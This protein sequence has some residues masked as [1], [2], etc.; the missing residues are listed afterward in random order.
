MK[1]VRALSV[2]ALFACA[3]AQA[4]ESPG[5]HY[6]PY[7]SSGI[8]ALGE[9]AG[10]HVTLPWGSPAANYVIR[11]NNLT[12]IGRGRIVPGKPATIE[13]KLD[14]P[15]MV[16]VEVTENSPGA[17]P[18]ALGAAVAPEQI[19]PAIPAPAD[20]DAFW[21]AK[22][23]ALRKVPAKP[24]LT[25]KPSD[26]DGVDFAILRMDHLDGKHVWGQVAKPRDPSGKKKYPGLVL[27]Q[28]ASPPYP[29]QKPW[30]TDRAAE[31][32]LAVN[33]EP[34]DVMPDQPR[35]YYDALPEALKKYN[36][37][38][39][40]NRDRNYFLYMYL[41]DIRAVDYL[42]SRK[43]WD[44][45]TLVVM[46]TSMGGQQSLCTAAFHPKVTA[47]LVN[48]PAGADANGTA[49]GRKTG[50]PNWDFNDTKVLETAQYFDT[51]NCAGRIKVP[52]LVS[53]GFIDTVTPPVGIWAAYNQI[54]GPKQAAPMPESPHNHLAT[55]EQSMPWTRAS[56]NW[57]SA[58]VAGRQPIE[59]ADFAMPRTDANS[60]K[61]HDELLAKRKAGQIDLYFM[62]DSITRRWGT[63]DEQYQDLLANWN[64]NFKGW[65]AANF[66][67]GADRTQNM[68]WRLQNGELDGVNPKVV[69][70]LAGTNNVGNATPLGDAEARAADVARGVTALVRE[71]RSRAPAATL[72]ITG[73]TPRDDNLSVMPVIDSANR[74]IARLADGKSIRYININEQIAFPDGRLRDG[75]AFDGLHLTPKAY[76]HWADA[77]K[78]ILTEIL[79]PPAAVD[80]A[81]P[82]SGDPSA[83]RRQSNS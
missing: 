60:M 7:K 70:L 65:N 36:T 81:P 68:L 22:L 55:P 17:K 61:A 52:S 53:M 47:M 44:G 35:E 51:V 32:W 41:A 71:I 2:A 45:K 30:V 4:D 6:V 11:Q 59:R 76:Q 27:L 9:T 1:S 57:L 49:H 56:A 79:G 64:A 78:P 39:T 18:K 50:Y 77:L 72:V 10:W 82:P 37:I 42:A 73:I 69:V 66:G 31:G 48:V 38:E 25:E 74:Q 24:Q 29:L 21:K 8:Y 16:F 62:G 40:R 5:P 54:K 34:H 58:L 83:V 3:A 33:I 63:S 19:G 14:A 80:R 26:K 67:W 43:D 75:M 46:G 23:T 15:G 20:F 13:A 28:W 12:E